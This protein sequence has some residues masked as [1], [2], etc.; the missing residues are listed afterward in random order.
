MWG[1][2]TTGYLAAWA[3]VAAVVATGLLHLLLV[4]VARPSAYSPGSPPW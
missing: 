3:A 4:T 1:D 2:A